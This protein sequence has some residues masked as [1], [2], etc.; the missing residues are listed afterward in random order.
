MKFSHFFLAVLPLLAIGCDEEKPWPDPPEVPEELVF[1]EF[2]AEVNV[3][4]DSDFSKT[5]LKDELLTSVP[6]LYSQWG[7]V[8]SIPENTSLAIKDAGEDY[9]SVL[10]ITNGTNG[11]SSGSYHQA[12]VGQRVL[13][14]AKPAMYRLGFKAR[15]VSGNGTL[16][17]FILAT[18]E[19]GNIVKK[20]FVVH[21]NQDDPYEVTPSDKEYTMFCTHKP[22]TSEWV[23]Y[24]VYFN[25]GRTTDITAKAK[26]STSKAASEVDLK[27]FAV[28]FSS[29]NP[30][31]E[32]QIDNVEFYLLKDKEPDA[33][34]KIP[35]VGEN[36][37]KDSDFEKT[38]LSK[39]I[40]SLA[41]V[42]YGEWGINNQENVLSY[43]LIEDNI[44]GQCIKMTCGET[45][46]GSANLLN[47]YIGQRL[48]TQ[49]SKEVYKITYKAK[50]LTSDG[51]LRIF[52]PV[53][54]NNVIQK[55][56]FVVHYNNDDPYSETPE[57]QKYTM[58]CRHVQLTDDWGEYTCYFDLRRTTTK[59]ASATF[60]D[61]NTAVSTDSDLQ[62]FLICFS[63]SAKN[64]EILIDD[65]TVTRIPPKTEN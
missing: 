36:I 25:M 62:K 38:D 17:T 45:S 34:L 51:T 22:L 27:G 49:G 21:H 37:V 32:I 63:S 1:E 12:Y 35:E 3:I 52:M 54:E 39:D 5:E 10:S 11:I 29:G 42:F 47:S 7:I 15:A 64:S 44:Q 58:H 60:D 14:K 24:T 16:R 20:F 43:E 6:T 56:F 57:G 18:D 30:S 41:P 50:K 2:P 65:V 40:T 9:G 19:N 13:A 28:C 61:T 4:S 33:P 26:F 23:D 48:Y 53:T 31:S 46:V 55:K 8:N 59:T